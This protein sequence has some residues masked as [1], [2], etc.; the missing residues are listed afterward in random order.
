[1]DVLLRTSNVF[2]GRGIQAF[3]FSR[4]RTDEDGRDDRENCAYDQCGEPDGHN[5]GQGINGGWRQETKS[6]KTEDQAEPE[7]FG[8]LGGVGRFL[9]Q[10]G[11]GE[12]E[13][14]ADDFLDVPDDVLKDFGYDRCI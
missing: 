12:T 4:T 7:S 9:A 6:I 11:L 13:L 1:L 10:F 8:G 14:R 3:Q 5:D 2:I